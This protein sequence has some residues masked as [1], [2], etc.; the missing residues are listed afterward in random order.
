[1]AFEYH[2]EVLGVRYRTV[3]EEL[4]FTNYEGESLKGL[5]ALRASASYVEEG[6]ER[7]EIAERYVYRP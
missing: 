7:E 5:Y 3:I 4:K 2:D 6:E 1:M